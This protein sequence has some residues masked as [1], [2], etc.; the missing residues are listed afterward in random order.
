MITYMKYLESLSGRSVVSVSIA[1]LVVVGVIDYLTGVELSFS[2]LYLLPVALVSWYLNRWAGVTMAMVSAVVWYLVDLVSSPSYSTPVVPYW[3]ATVMFGFF[4]STAFVLSM[5]KQATDREKRLAREIQARLLPAEIPRIA[6]YEI[7]G[8]W[9]PAQ[10]VSGDYYDVIR[11]DDA[12]VILCIGDVAGHGIPA[13]L[14]MSNLQAAVRML[15]LSKLPPREFCARLNTFVFNN[16]TRGN[17]ITFFYG[18]LDVSKR[19]LVYTNAGHNR[20]LILRD[21]GETVSLSEGGFALGLLEEARYNQGIT[22]LEEGDLLVIYTD[23]VIEVTDA[24]HEQF[25]ENRFVNV[26]GENRRR[27]A[28]AACHA[29]L[30]AVS[31]FSKAKYDDDI[32]LLA[33]SVH[34][35][36]LC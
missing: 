2:I 22:C 16:T 21:S 19:E 17:F 26:L 6:G 25:G 30:A 9:Q 10:S 31:A 18:V 20:P 4:F 34:A 5:L 15:A 27:G 3:N 13:A 33:L 8:A 35:N 32:T 1:V 11:P 14:L 28:N 12:S 7:A 36:V 23:G 24:K 29:I